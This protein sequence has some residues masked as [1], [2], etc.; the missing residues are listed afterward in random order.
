MP[1]NF[2]TTVGEFGCTELIRMKDLDWSAN[3]ISCTF[4]AVGDTV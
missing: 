3:F 2:E 4:T 1:G